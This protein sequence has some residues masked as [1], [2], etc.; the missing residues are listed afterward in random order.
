MY[1][2]KSERMAKGKYEYWLTDDGLTLLKGWARRGLTDEQIAHNMRIG[3]S[4]LYKWK[5]AHVEI[6][7]ALNKT[8]E[9][10][11]DQV[12]CALLKRALGYD[13]EESKTEDDGKGNIKVTITKRH[14][15]PDS[16]SLIFWLKNR[17]R[18][19]WRD[20][21]DE[22]VNTALLE[23]AEELLGGVNSVIDS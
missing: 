3:V 12:E 14:I 15:P 1:A 19:D 9:I 4:T 18:K 8:K 7:E 16:T 11:D 6:R 5:N 13:V 22:E 21:P 10:I 17:R 2:E 20:H 23:K